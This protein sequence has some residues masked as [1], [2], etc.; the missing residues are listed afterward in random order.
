MAS[1]VE[2]FVGDPVVLECEVSRA[3]AQV[4]WKKDGEEM[5]ESRNITIIEDGIS[6]QLTIRSSTLE[7]SGQYICDAKDD[8][9]D[10]T[11]K[12]SGKC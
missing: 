5:E 12:I 2:S 4:S 9:M 11:V 3:S 8:V 1:T 10:F 7:D 6:R